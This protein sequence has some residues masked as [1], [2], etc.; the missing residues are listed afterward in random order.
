MPF[1]KTFKNKILSA[2]CG[3]SNFTNSIY[4]ALFIGNPEG[5]T[6][7]AEVSATNYGYKRTLVC[8]YNS[9]STN[10]MGTPSE[11]SVANTA[12]IYFPEATGSWGTVD[13]VALYDSLT[14]GNLLGYA[15][16][17]NDSGTDTSLEINEGKVPLIRTGKFTISFVDAQ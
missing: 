17:V 15:H 14:G 7:G 3:K 10:L 12:T 4:A 2:I 13:Y 8:G 1:T 9:G 11:G 6:P 16:I 5:T